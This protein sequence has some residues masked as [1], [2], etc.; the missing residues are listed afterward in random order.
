MVMEWCSYT[1][2]QCYGW[3]YY[4]HVVEAHCYALQYRRIDCEQICSRIN[5]QLIAGRFGHESLRQLRTKLLLIII[6]SCVAGEEHAYIQLIYVYRGHLMYLKRETVYVLTLLHCWFKFKLWYNK[7]IKLCY[8][9]LTLSNI[10]FVL[11][12][13]LNGAN[14]AICVA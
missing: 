4:N 5:Q 7:N 1:Q 6:I 2:E 8:R 14:L 13:V 9:N 3:H 11:H 12:N 10:M